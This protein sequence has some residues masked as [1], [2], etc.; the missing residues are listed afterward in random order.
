ME[1]VVDRLEGGYAVLLVGHEEIRVD[2]PLSLLPSG[3]AEGDWLKIN[4]ELNPEKTCSRRER[5]QNL[6][7][8]LKSEEGL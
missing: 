5:V 8:K 1:A 6:L 7:D 2:I 4:F 3:I